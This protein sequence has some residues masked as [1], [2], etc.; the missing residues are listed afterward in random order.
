[1]K[2]KLISDRM[3]SSDNKFAGYNN[4][5]RAELLEFEFPE[6]LKDYT[7]TIN[8]ETT[9]GNFFDILDGDTYILKNNINLLIEYKYDV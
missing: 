5:N 7:K 8:F 3:L 9:E 4:E 1:M 6:N 2:F